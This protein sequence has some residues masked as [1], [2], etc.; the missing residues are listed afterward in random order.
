MG[1]F[2]V[3]G[4]R[5]LFLVC[6]VALSLG[7]GAYVRLGSTGRRGSAPASAAPSAAAIL[8]NTPVDAGAF[9]SR[10]A[11]PFR[12]TDQF[13]RPVTLAQF[14]GRVVVLAFIDDQCTTICPLT[15]ESMVGAE[16]LLG[17]RAARHM[18]L[19]A[20]NANPVATSVA[21]VRQYS[22]AHGLMNRWLFLTAPPATLARVWKQYGI[23]VAVI[24]GA[25]DH[26][27][28]LYVIAPDGRERWVAETAME[29]RAVNTEALVLARVVQTLLPKAAQ[30]PLPRLTVPPPPSSRT[31]SLPAITLTGGRK[32]VALGGHGPTLVVF[33]ASW[34]P[35]LASRWRT[36]AAQAH[37]HANIRVVLVDIGTVEP[38]PASFERFMAMNPSLPPMPVAYDATGQLSDALGA[39]NIPAS[40]LMTGRGQVLWRSQSWPSTSQW[41]HFQQLLTKAGRG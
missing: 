5:R 14:R 37:A 40:V 29:Y 7:L 39:Q 33:V 16:R 25:I 21:D 4:H 38:S 18:V 41:T 26:T 17:V 28:A 31:A 15:M 1:D 10:S 35:D 20:V 36:L 24:H 12:L 32:T 19:L 13:G 9:L 2:L 8:A 23:Y 27:P 22:A 30:H 11:P 34:A 3:R 6:L